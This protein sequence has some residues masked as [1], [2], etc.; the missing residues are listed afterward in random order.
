M[1][2]KHLEGLFEDMEEVL[3]ER[4]RLIRLLLSIIGE[5]KTDGQFVIRRKGAMHMLPDNLAQHLQDAEEY[6]A[7]ICPVYDRIGHE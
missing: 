7:Q 6:I 3:E 5:C 2:R 1:T 4:A